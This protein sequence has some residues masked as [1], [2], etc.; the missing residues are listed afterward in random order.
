MLLLNDFPNYLTAAKTV[1]FAD[2]SN[3]LIVDND[4]KNFKNK[5]NSTTKGIQK[6]FSENRMVL[7][8]NKTVTVNFNKCKNENVTLYGD[9]IK[10]VNEVKFLGVAVEESLKWSSHIQNL[11]PK[12]NKTIYILRVL[13]EYS[14]MEVLK[15]IY[16]S[17]FHSLLTYGVV[18]WGNH[19]TAKQVFL[20]QKRA[21]RIMCNMS[22]RDSCRDKFKSL[23]IMTFPSIYI[24]ETLK[25]VKSN[26]SIFP[27]IEI[28]IITT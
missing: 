3:V 5:V 17:K 20:V 14:N 22:P 19:S 21:L 13:K 4:E 23:G 1:L 16:F 9:S 6:W 26:I 2:D 15:T 18:I 27:K 25:Y 28:N 12:L 11:I 7:N 24:Y 8:L 10:I